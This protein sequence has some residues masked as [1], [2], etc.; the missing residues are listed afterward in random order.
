MV[1]V[2]AALLVLAALAGLVPGA[3]PWV[4]RMAAR[5]ADHRAYAA[6]VLHDKAIRWPPVPASH[7]PAID[8]LTALAAVAGAVVL[9]AI[10]LFGRPLRRQLPRALS[11]AAAAATRTLR[12]LHSGHIGD[13]IAWWTAGTTAVGAVCMI[14]LR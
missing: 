3:V 9:A 12:G 4:E 14:A 8:V 7:V 11:D 2:P 5:F 13:Y 1:A 6:W 10:G